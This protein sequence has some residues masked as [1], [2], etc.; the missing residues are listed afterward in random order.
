MLRTALL[1]ASRSAAVRRLVER[2]PTAAVVD[3]FVAGGRADEAV[4]VVRGLTADRLVTV[5]HLGEDTTDRARAEAI[6]AAYRTL[7]AR[8]AAEGLAGRAEGVGH[9][10]RAGAEAPRRRREDHPGRGARGVRG[11]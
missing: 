11:R 8:L 10:L 2:G 9:A 3:R 7:L 5:D 6:A 4:A 1:A